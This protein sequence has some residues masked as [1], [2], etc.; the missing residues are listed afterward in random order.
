MFKQPIL[1]IFAVQ[2]NNET[3]SKLKLKQTVI[4]IVL[5]GSCR[6]KDKSNVLIPSPQSSS[7]RGIYGTIHVE[8]YSD[9]NL[10]LRNQTKLIDEGINYEPSRKTGCSR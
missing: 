9:L 4:I 2:M 10:L 6:L 7:T 8:I 5:G 1:R 3:K